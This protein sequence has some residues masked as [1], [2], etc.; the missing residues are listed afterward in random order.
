MGEGGKR[1]PTFGAAGQVNREGTRAHGQTRTHGRH[2]RRRSGERRG[3]TPQRLQGGRREGRFAQ[4]TPSGSPPDAGHRQIGPDYF[5]TLGIAITQG[6]DFDERDTLLTQ[7]AAII[8]ET[9]ARRYWPNESPLLKRFSF[10][11]DTPTGARV[12]PLAI[13]GVAADVARRAA[14][15]GDQAG[16]L[17]AARQVN[18]NSSWIPSYRMIRTA[19]DPVSVAAAARCMLRPQSAR[20]RHPHDGRAFGSTR[21]AAALSYDAADGVRLALLLAAIGIYGVLADFVAQHASEIGL[22]MALGAQ[23]GDVMHLV[24]RRGMS[25]TLV[26]VTL[27][28][29]A[30]WTVTR[31]MKTLVFGVGVADP[32]DLQRHRA[33]AAIRR[34]RCLLDSSQAA[35]HASIR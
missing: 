30:A 35:R 32:N 2:R 26:G 13:V 12:P 17:C 11:D 28:L 24:L 1:I 19:G 4:S 34:A 7:P 6:R 10:V 5:R 14:R 29:L 27:G 25:L 15:D 23:T 3:R 16:V 33:D 20:G 31:L 9:I 8:N 21:R 22:R 18:Y